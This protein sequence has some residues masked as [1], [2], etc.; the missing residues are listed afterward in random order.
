MWTVQVDRSAATLSHYCLTS[1][2]QTP[3]LFCLQAVATL[4]AVSAY[5]DGEG[6]GEG[7]EAPMKAARDL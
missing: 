5:Y 6:R 1:S 2:A 4:P 7:L 3:P